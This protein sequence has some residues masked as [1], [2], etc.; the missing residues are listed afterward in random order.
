LSFPKIRGDVVRPDATIVHFQ[1]ERGVPHVLR[2]DG[3][4]SR[5][6]QHEIDHL[7]GVLFI[8]RMTKPAKAK[9]NDEIKAL[10][11]ETRDAAKA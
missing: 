11:K 1:D 5:C 2:S 9:V 6:I 7:N 3:L 8:D 4:L 10:A